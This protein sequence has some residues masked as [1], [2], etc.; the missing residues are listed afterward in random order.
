KLFIKSE[1]FKNFCLQNAE[2]NNKASEKLKKYRYVNVEIKSMDGNE[3]L[4]LFQILIAAKLFSLYNEHLPKVRQSSESRII[5]SQAVELACEFGLLISLIARCDMN[6]AK[7]SSTS[8]S[9][10]E[11]EKSISVILADTKRLSNLY[12]AFGYVQAGCI[13][14][15]LAEKILPLDEE[16]D[17]IYVFC[18]ESL[19]NFLCATL[20]ADHPYSRMIENS[21]IS[22]ELGSEVK[23]GGLKI[24]T[25]ED[26]KLLLKEWSGSKENFE[27]IQARAQAEIN[28]L[29]KNN[30][31]SKPSI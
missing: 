30:N 15:E 16:K 5:C 17:R 24:E 25:Q 7:I 4:S 3:S 9:H 12:W 11:R 22:D 19:K 18:E 2:F 6:M 13:L 1:R 8:T 20:L 23:K 31:E 10:E 14:Q 29:L 26:A 28:S 27:R 21:L